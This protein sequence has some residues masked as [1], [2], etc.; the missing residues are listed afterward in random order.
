MIISSSRRTDIP[1]F[2]A[3]WF[4]QR[5]RAGYCLVPNPFKPEHA[6]RVSLTP[7]DI[8]VIVFWTRHP[9]PLFPY[10]DELD[11]RG[12]RYYFQY[13]LL[14]NPS[15]IDPKTPALETALKTFRQLADRI[16]PEKV[17]W[18]YDPLVF[19][20]ITDA[21]FH[22]QAFQYIAHQVRGYTSRAVISLMDYYRKLNKRLAALAQAGIHIQ[23]L[24]TK[25][26]QLSPPEFVDQFKDLMRSLAQTASENS[27][28]ITS[29]AEEI[30]L[31][32]YGIRH[33]KCIDDEL[34]KKVFG[35][36]VS[37][38]KDPSQRPTCGCVASKDIGVY[39]TCLF[40]CQ[41]CYATTSFEQAR[42][43]YERHDPEAAAM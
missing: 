37:S 42:N 11:R 18:R 27:M 1:A 19:S 28:E 25:T 3:D 23:P 31:R 8:D 39:N 41:Y 35:L 30:D 22:R 40:G 38:Q 9:R 20:N 43:N 26:L 6:A 14:N 32:P 21:N 12:Y 29:C 15:E 36:E 16:G 5:I 13:T 24:N 7:E 34:I 10:L 17:I 2:Y 33:G 4:M